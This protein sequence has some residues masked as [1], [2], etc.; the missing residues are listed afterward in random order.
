MLDTF[1]YFINITVSNHVQFTL[2]IALTSETRLSEI[3]VR[4][5]C[6]CN[7]LAGFDSPHNHPKN[8]EYI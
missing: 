2:F 4:W 6:G 8:R 1:K 7:Q 5:M 3:A